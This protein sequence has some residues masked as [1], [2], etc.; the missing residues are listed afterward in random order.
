MI[1]PASARVLE[2]GDGS[3]SDALDGRTRYDQLSFRRFGLD[4]H[5]RISRAAAA[6]LDSTSTRILSVRVSL[7]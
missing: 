1:L 2:I 4:L 7:R 6:A 3:I 5:V